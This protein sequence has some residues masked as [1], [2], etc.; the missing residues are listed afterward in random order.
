MDFNGAAL[1]SKPGVK[2]MPAA[3]LFCN[4][5]IVG[6][7]IPSVPFAEGYPVL[8]GEP[9]VGSLIGAALPPFSP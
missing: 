6:C 3:A 5:S 7:A 2:R 8:D 4:G 9:A 1:G